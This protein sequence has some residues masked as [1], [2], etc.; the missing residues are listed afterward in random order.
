MD[1][2]KPLPAPLAWLL[3]APAAPSLGSGVVS[4]REKAAD[5]DDCDARGILSGIFTSVYAT[6]RLLSNGR[7]YC[8]GIGGV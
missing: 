4:P 2:C 3:P 5:S 7:R 6:Y 8:G 1:E